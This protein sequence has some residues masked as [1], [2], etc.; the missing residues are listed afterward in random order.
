MSHDAIRQTIRARWSSHIPSGVPV[1]ELKDRES[2][3]VFGQVTVGGVT[4]DVGRSLEAG[5]PG[6]IRG[7]GDVVWSKA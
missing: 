6:Q 7:N 5:G 1:R 2:M 3:M 4:Y